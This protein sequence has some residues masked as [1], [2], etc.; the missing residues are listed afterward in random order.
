MKDYYRILEIDKKATKSE[1]VKSFRLLAK[2]YHPDLNKSADASFKF[3]EIYEAYEILVDEH[4]RIS[5]DNIYNNFYGYTNKQTGANNESDYIN[6]TQKAQENANKYSHLKYRDFAKNVLKLSLGYI[7]GSAFIVIL[8]PLVYIGVFIEP[9]LLALI[10]LYMPYKSNEIFQGFAYINLIIGIAFGIFY[11]INF[12]ESESCGLLSSIRNTKK[13]DTGKKAI[14]NYLI[15]LGIVLYSVG[16]Y[17]A[18]SSVS[19]K[20]TADF[21][22]RFSDMAIYINQLDAYFPESYNYWDIKIKQGVIVIDMDKKCIDYEI[23]KNLPESIIA[24]KYESVNTLIQVWRT[25][26]VVGKY[27]DNAEGIQRTCKYKIIDLKTPEVTGEKEL[28]GSMPPSTKKSSGTAYGSNP[29]PDFVQ[30]IIKNT[31]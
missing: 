19:E 15:F 31:K 2:K 29:I 18:A 30:L 8:M 13:I 17:F 7:L 4:K 1:I 5:Y 24:F 21:Q 3:R 9:I 12:F 27:T 10:I 22:N 23:M 11:Y 25:E 28:K 20:K 14:R 6:W 16:I 26:T